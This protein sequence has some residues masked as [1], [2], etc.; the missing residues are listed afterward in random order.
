[1]TIDYAGAEEFIL[2][3]LKAELPRDLHYH[4]IHHTLDVYEAAV[5]IADRTIAVGYD[6]ANGGLW[7]VADA[8][9]LSDRD[10]EW[11]PQIEAVVGFLRVWKNTGESRFSGAALRSW[12]FI[13]KHLPDPENGEWFWGLKADGT[14]NRGQDKA[15][16]WK[17]PYHNSRGCMEILSLLRPVL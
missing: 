16:L 9:G 2:N 10:K 11:W 6:P 14:P 13:E 15:G 8:H 5:R 3:K 1:M 4:G 7:N 17:C 12:Q